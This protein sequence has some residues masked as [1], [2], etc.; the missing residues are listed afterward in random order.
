MI[1]TNKLANKETNKIISLLSGFTVKTCRL[2]TMQVWRCVKGVITDE[3]VS[4]RCGGR[5]PCGLS[6][7]QLIQLAA[8]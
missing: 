1:K 8:A 2:L 3:P 6:L 4:G 7:I 5:S